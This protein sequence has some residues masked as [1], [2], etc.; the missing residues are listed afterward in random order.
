M[1]NHSNYSLHQAAR[2]PKKN[3]P[4]IALMCF[5][6]EE[7]GMHDE[8]L[9]CLAL[10]LKLQSRKCQV[11]STCLQGYARWL[12]IYVYTYAGFVVSFH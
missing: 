12:Y 8:V 1:S 3:P 6:R 2:L 5:F 7:G 4:I 9:E 11:L 10:Y